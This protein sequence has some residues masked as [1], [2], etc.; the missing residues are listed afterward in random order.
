MRVLP[1]HAG[2]DAGFDQVGKEPTPQ[3]WRADF[4]EFYS[5]ID[6]TNFSVL[7]LPTHAVRIFGGANCI[8]I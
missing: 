7:R 1:A 6:H 4:S 8:S 3:G 2:E 5:E